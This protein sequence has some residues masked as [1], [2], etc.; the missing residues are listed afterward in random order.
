MERDGY[1]GDMNAIFT[2]SQDLAGEEAKDDN[3]DKQ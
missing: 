3:H 2:I 1:M